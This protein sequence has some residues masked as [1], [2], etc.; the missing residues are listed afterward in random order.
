MR[1]IS[2]NSD[3]ETDVSEALDEGFS[4]SSL[5]HGNP[6]DIISAI[7]TSVPIGAKI[8]QYLCSQCH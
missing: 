4:G 6:G 7:L 1:T 2:A 5:F 8:T 3:A